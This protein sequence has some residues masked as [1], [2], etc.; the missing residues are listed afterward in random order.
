MGLQLYKTYKKHNSSALVEWH[1]TAG[2]K[3]S[4]TSY[5][6]NNWKCLHPKSHQDVDDVTYIYSRLE[7]I[8]VVEG[9]C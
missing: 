7:C 9:N 3:A 5:S 6:D 1:S 8:Q 4:G 2:L